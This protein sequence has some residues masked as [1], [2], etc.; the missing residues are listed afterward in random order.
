MG[1]QWVC[2][3]HLWSTSM[4]IASLQRGEKLWPTKAQKAKCARVHIFICSTVTGPERALTGHQISLLFIPHK[5]EAL[6]AMYSSLLLHIPPILGN[7]TEK[8][9]TFLQRGATLPLQLSDQ[10]STRAFRTGIGDTE[11]GHK[12][13]SI[14]TKCNKLPKPWSGLSVHYY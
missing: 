11:K 2:L 14:Y 12:T 5:K 6:K 13:S 4:P 10:S 1:G 3:R 8:D 7:S 9:V